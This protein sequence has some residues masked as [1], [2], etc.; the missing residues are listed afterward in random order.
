MSSKP[1]YNWNE[2]SIFPD[3][4]LHPASMEYRGIKTVLN[5]HGEKVKVAVITKTKE[6]FVEQARAIWGNRYDYTDS[7][8]INNRKPITIYCPKHD[9]HFR[10]AMAQNHILKP[11]G[12][13]KPTGCPVC[14]AE[15]LHGS[16][17]GKD[18]RRYLKVCAKNNRVGRIVQPPQKHFKSPEQRAA[19]EAARQAEAEAKR[20]KKKAYMEKWHAK[21]MKEAAFF[22]KLQQQYPDQY[23]T[24]KT[25]YKGREGK[26][27]L[28]C[29]VHGPFVITPR[30]LFSNDARNKAHGCWKCEGRK[31]PNERP[32]QMTADE[33]FNKMKKLYGDRFDFSK[34][35]FS[36]IDD[37]ITF[38]CKKHGE[39]KNK[40]D[41]LLN[42]KGCDYCNGRR[43]WGPDFERLAREKHGD[44]YD[45]SKVGEIKGKKD[46]VT[47]ICPEHGEFP[48][49]VDL[50]LAGY[51]CREC[52]NY[53]NKKSPQQRCNEW[54]KKCIEKYGEGRYDYSR[55][56][57]DYVNNDSLVWIRC[58]IHDHWFQTTPDNNLR[59]VN[60]SCPICS[61]EFRESEGEATIRRW[62]QNHGILDFEQ[63][64]ALPNEDP[65]LP[66]QYLSADF[67]MLIGR[68][69][70]IIEYHGE[71][72]YEEIPFFYEGRKLRT[73]EVQQHRDRYLRKYCKDHRIRLIEI[74]YWDYNRIDEILEST[75]L[76]DNVNELT[77]H[78]ANP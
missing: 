21:S 59:T 44:K 16:E 56:H 75:L 54:I 70:I 8:Y 67:Y 71:Q 26:L 23:D 76:N 29:P 46:I 61:M 6:R 5:K 47:I 15:K 11:H 45:Y 42:G 1:K 7:V 51:G 65:T 49:R 27:T 36:G 37:S 68:E 33:F 19:E 2:P 78:S 58:C 66:L 4:N 50:H 10:V 48:Q 77:N 64:H 72:H 12:T 34:S 53:P 39:Q 30:Q 35:E 69:Y 20:L 43:F 55:A 18:W 14:A 31:D 60:G 25:E 28:I 41:T 13:F 52:A 38:I 74:P 40:A 3:D 22:E 57:E 73:F 62:L 9:Y 63:E 24:S 17:Y 32:P